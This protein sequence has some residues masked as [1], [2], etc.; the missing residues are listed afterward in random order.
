MTFLKVTSSSSY[1][2]FEIYYC[3]SEAEVY[4]KELQEMTGEPAVCVS[5]RYI[6]MGKNKRNPVLNCLF[7]NKVFKELHLL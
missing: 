1:L 2:F 6:D 5:K 3:I 7:F 4:E